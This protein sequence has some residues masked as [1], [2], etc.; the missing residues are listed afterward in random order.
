MR[1][2]QTLAWSNIIGQ[3]GMSINFNE[4]RSFYRMAVNFC[5][6]FTTSNDP[7]IYT[8]KGKNLSAAGLKLITEHEVVE[9]QN[10]DI[11][12]HPVV[13][14]REPLYTKAR[15]VRVDKD[16]QANKYIVGLSMKELN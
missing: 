12:V 16:Q 14:M 8:G 4:R 10:L 7:K 1:C 6:E 15:V 9:G 2:M 3:S 5:I 11:I 13:Q